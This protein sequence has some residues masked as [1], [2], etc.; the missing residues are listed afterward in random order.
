MFIFEYNGS[1]LRLPNRL[2]SLVQQEYDLYDALELMDVPIENIKEIMRV[3]LPSEDDFRIDLRSEQI[4][5]LNNIETDRM[6]AQW[7]DSLYEVQFTFVSG[8][9]VVNA[10]CSSSSHLIKVR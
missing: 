10:Y 8:S 5:W 1:D 9:V 7:P 6:Y 4:L 2:Y 3:D